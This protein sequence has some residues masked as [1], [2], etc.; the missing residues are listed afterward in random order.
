M[1]QPAASLQNKETVCI[2]F[3]NLQPELNPSLASQDC[4]VDTTLP[5]AVTD[6]TACLLHNFTPDVIYRTSCCCATTTFQLIAVQKFGCTLYFK[7]KDTTVQRFYPE[8]GPEQT[9][10]GPRQLCRRTANYLSLTV[11]EGAQCSCM[12]VRCMGVRCMGVRCMR[13]GCVG[14]RC[15]RVG[16]V[17]VRCMRVGCVWVRC[18]G[19]GC[20]G[21]RCTPGS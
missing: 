13:V 9:C 5:P 16:C 8:P 7:A 11:P 19:V 14:V 2:Q 20:M 17:G 21:V 18:Q 6:A 3:A 15:M 10:K 4:A 12:G 1:T